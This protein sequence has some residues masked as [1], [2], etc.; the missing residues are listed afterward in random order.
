MD[1]DAQNVL[2][3]CIASGAPGTWRALIPK[4]PWVWAYANGPNIIANGATAPIG[5][6]LSEAGTGIAVDPAGTA[7]VVIPA[8]GVYAVSGQAYLVSKGPG[9]MASKVFLSTGSFVMQG[10]Q[11]FPTASTQAWGLPIPTFYQRFTAGTVLRLH[12]AQ[13]TGGVATVLTGPALTYLQVR[14]VG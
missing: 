5:L 7:G 1:L 6:G 8:A 2:Y 12:A 9:L 10:A 11:V 14:R 3:V 4:L 13:T